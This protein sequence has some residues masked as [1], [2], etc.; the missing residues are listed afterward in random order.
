MRTALPSGAMF[1][2]CHVDPFDTR[3]EKTPVTKQTT[4]RQ[5][6]QLIGRCAPLNLPYAVMINTS[7]LL[8]AALQQQLKEL[9]SVRTA[10]FAFL[11]L[12]QKWK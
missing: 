12:E 5:P 6:L 7:P 1:C 10:A 4:A 11:L 8:S 9:L 3:S 2:S